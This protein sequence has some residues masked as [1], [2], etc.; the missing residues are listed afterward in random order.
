MLALKQSRFTE[1]QINGYLNEG[2][3][4]S[5]LSDRILPEGISE[6]RVLLEPDKVR[7]AFR[8]GSGPWSTVV[9]LDFHVWLSRHE[10]ARD[11]DQG[12]EA[13][14]ASPRAIW[15]RQ[16]QHVPLLERHARVELARH[17]DQFAAD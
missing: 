14:D 5:G 4:Q 9:T 1:Q 6:P 8:Y 11:V 13:S 17:L 15:H 3:V 16:V 7:L 12:I 2:F 10:R